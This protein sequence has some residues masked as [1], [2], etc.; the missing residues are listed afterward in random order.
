MEPFANGSLRTPDRLCPAAYVLHM[1][2]R[3]IVRPR[4]GNRESL[5]SLQQWLLLSI[6]RGE[7]F[8]FLH[9]F[10]FKIE[11]VIADAIST[12]WHHVYPHIISYLLCTID[13]K[14]NGPLYNELTYEVMTYMPASLDDHRHGQ[15]S[16]R[17][18]QVLLPIQ[19]RERHEMV[20]A[21]LE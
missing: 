7:Q 1:Y 15:H 9:F 6:W 12:G 17:S 19:D 8:D 2:L 16:L 20:D 14:K 18:V 10:L 5:T 11:D 21:T 3:K 4:G 13:S